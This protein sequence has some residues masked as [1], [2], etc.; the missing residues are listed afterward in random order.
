MANF[1]SMRGP[2]GMNR[3]YALTDPASA[4]GARTDASARRERW[5][6][7]LRAG[8]TLATN[9]PLLGLTVEGQPP[10][11]EL[12]VPA[13]ETTLK[14]SGFLRSVVPVD[15]LEL[16]VNGKVARTIRLTGTRTSADFAG[17]LA[18]A[19]GGWLLVRAWNDAAD[20]EI[21]DI[22]PY[23]TTNAFFLRPPGAAIHC[24]DDAQFFL[25]WLGRLD[26]AASAHEGYNSAA[27]RETT[28]SQIR[29]ARAIMSERR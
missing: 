9:G 17:R 16:I 20:P 8:R 23:A 4:D 29:A 12:A 27:E 28:L 22:Y 14:Y 3:V 15:H 24:G 25:D 2:V 5:L 7:G 21:F 18:V 10:G 19:R 11:T 13:G 6:A 26:A 1:A